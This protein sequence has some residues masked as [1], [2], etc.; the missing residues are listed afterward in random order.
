MKLKS[1]IR[2]SKKELLRIKH[3]LEYLDKVLMLDLQYQENIHKIINKIEN[4]MRGE[5][6]EIK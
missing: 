2:F 5:I 4:S 6:D 3:G 1:Y